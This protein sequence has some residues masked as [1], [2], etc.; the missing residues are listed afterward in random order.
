VFRSST[1]YFAFIAGY[2]AGTIQNVTIKNSSLYVKGTTNVLY[3]GGIAGHNFGAGLIEDCHL[4][5]V[6]ISV[7]TS[8]SAIVGGI[9][10]TND[11]RES[12]A[13]TPNKVMN[14]SFEGSIKVVIG[15]SSTISS[16]VNAKIGGLVG[17]NNSYVGSSTV[18]ALITVKTDARNYTSSTFNLYVG[19]AVGHNLRD[20]SSVLYGVN[21]KTAINLDAKD[22]KDIA[23][24][25]V[26]GYNGG[27]KE[28]SS[29]QVLSCTFEAKEGENQI[30]ALADKV[31]VNNVGLIGVNKASNSEVGFDG[32]VT[33]TVNEFETKT[34]EEA[35][36][37]KS[38]LVSSNGTNLA[39]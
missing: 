36:N 13:T 12:S 37:T 7:S 10:G 24:G 5:N 29:A 9:I 28:T 18:D 11:A 33:V 39:E 1:A 22:A 16:Q 31:S 26:V 3:A 17:Y 21:V 19:G 4:D 23:Y 2:N 34:S 27:S 6:A 25:F 35:L 32:S 20:G 38:L 8:A 15:T 30:N 14:C